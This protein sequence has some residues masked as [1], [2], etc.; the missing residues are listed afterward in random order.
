MDQ[1]TARDT[2]VEI[3]G[4]IAPEGDFEGL[5]P[6]TSLREQLDLDSLD[7]LVYVE[8][9]AER[10]GVEVREEDYPDV[11]GLDSCIAFLA[12]AAASR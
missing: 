5:D 1:S 11:D 4:D 10:T 2:I 8:K 3:L 7:F 6:Q 9:L 12:R